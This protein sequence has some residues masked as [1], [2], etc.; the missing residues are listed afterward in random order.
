MSNRPPI[1]VVA[2]GDP[3]KRDDGIAIRVMGRVRTLVA[4]LGMTRRRKRA[5]SSVTRGSGKEK[6][7]SLALA[8]LWDRERGRAGREAPDVQSR[9][10]E[11]PLIEWIEGGTEQQKLDSVLADRKRVVLLDAVRLTGKA[12]LVHHWH[13]AFNPQNNL[14]TVR[15]YGGRSQVGMQHLAL[16]LED[17]LPEEGTDLIGIEPH[18]LSDG[19]GLSRPIRARLPSIC[20]QVAALVVRILE[21]EGW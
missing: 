13:L 20:S 2:L 3:K 11:T 9:A 16:W 12:G 18:D 19:E 21:E 4:E 17:E 7:G 10:P 5:L 1:A 8:R 15:H 6:R 14:S